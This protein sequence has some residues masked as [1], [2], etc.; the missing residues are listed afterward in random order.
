MK[1]FYR[2]LL[3]IF[4]AL[5]VSSCIK[6]GEESVGKLFNVKYPSGESDTIFSSYDGTVKPLVSEDGVRFLKESHGMYR[7]D[8]RIIH[9]TSMATVSGDGFYNDVSL[10]ECDGNGNVISK[11][12]NENIREALIEKINSIQ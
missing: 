10:Y 2:K 3:P 4:G 11:I 1:G 5:V 6:S 9:Y 7:I 8:G 12:E